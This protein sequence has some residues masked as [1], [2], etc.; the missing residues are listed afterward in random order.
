MS[1]RSAVRSVASLL[2]FSVPLVAVG[3]D[4]AVSPDGAGIAEIVSRLDALEANSMAI[5]RCDVLY[6]TEDFADRD[7]AGYETRRGVTRLLLD[8]EHQ[9]C[10]Q[11]HRG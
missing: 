7:E 4:T 1:I 2:C 8:I 9:R 5:T 3:Q 11:F 10:A 6:V